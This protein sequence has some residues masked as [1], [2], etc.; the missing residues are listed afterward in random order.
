[1]RL[2]IEYLK[3]DSTGRPTSVM[4]VTDAG[5]FVFSGAEQVKAA[6]LDAIRRVNRA[7]DARL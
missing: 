2:E 5:R 1:M 3:F 7:A 6:C 4:I